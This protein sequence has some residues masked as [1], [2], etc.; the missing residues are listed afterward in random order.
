MQ[1]LDMHYS[2]IVNVYLSRDFNAVD[3]I[4]KFSYSIVIRYI[5][6]L[7]FL[8]ELTFSTLFL[9]PEQIEKF[10]DNFIILE[11][12]DDG[13]IK[14][15]KYKFTKKVFKFIAFIL[16]VIAIGLVAYVTIANK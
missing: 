10:L 5:D 6:N 13:C 4:P 1:K 3:F 8:K 9:K 14:Y 16:F 11:E 15:E 12:Q 2:R 7:N